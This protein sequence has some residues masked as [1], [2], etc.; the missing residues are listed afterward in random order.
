M[1]LFVAILD[2]PKLA[3]EFVKTDTPEQSKEFWKTNLA[4][5]G[6]RKRIYQA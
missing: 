4:S 2:E 1:E 3:R 5:G 6:I